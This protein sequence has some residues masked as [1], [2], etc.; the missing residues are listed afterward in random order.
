[1]ETFEKEYRGNV[2]VVTVNLVGATLNDTNEFKEFMNELILL[3][4]CSVVVD[5]SYCSHLDST[6]IGALVLSLKKMKQKERQLVLVEPRDHTK[7][8]LT[9]NSLNK[10]FRIYKNVN[11]AVED[12]LNRQF[13]ENNI[14]DSQIVESNK[15]IITENS[16]LKPGYEENT[17]LP[18][19]IYHQAEAVG[20]I[21]SEADLEQFDESIEET[22]QT[23]EKDTPV[24]IEYYSLQESESGSFNGTNE[25]AHI[26]N[27]SELGLR[28][29][30]RDYR[31]GSISWDFGL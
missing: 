27:Q 30:E 12:L 3:T 22:S 29:I 5:I 2:I 25:M 9:M 19:N 14:E 16:E 13:I 10:V 1:M 4:D 23:D 28:T 31:Q 18:D 7:I 20:S 15:G 26:E 6:F 17:P 8:F 11:D 21:K 24:D